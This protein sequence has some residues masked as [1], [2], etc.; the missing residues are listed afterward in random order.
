VSE[1]FLNQIKSFLSKNPR[2][3]HL[4]QRDSP[5]SKEFYKLLGQNVNQIKRM[6]VNVKSVQFYDEKYGSK[7]SS[8]LVTSKLM[9]LYMFFAIL[10]YLIVL[11]IAMQ[12]N[13]NFYK[14]I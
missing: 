9:E 12:V 14:Y 3:P 10:V 13:Y 2:A 4:I 11:Y 5:I 7:I 6:G 8:Y 1:A